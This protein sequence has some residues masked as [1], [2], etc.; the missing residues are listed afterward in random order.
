LICHGVKRPDIRDSEDAGVKFLQEFRSSGV[1]RST[2]E[3]EV[4]EPEAHHG[5]AR[6]DLTRNS[7]PADLGVSEK[8]EF[9]IAGKPMPSR[10]K[11]KLAVKKTTAPQQ[12][13]GRKHPTLRF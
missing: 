13:Q 5:G 3:S 7:H 12:Q 1:Q 8:N 2:G 10:R 4:Q 9:K 11:G 6:E